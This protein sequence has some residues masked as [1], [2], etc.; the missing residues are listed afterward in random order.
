MH[1]LLDYF[2]KYNLPRWSILIIDLLIC[3]FSLTLAFFLRFNFKSIPQ[4]ELDN[5]PLIYSV[6]LSVRLCAFIISKIY[7]GV[8]RY[9]GAR[10]ATRIF[11]IIL[12]KSSNKFFEWK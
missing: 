10:D 8:V 11:V 3:A 2:W 4:S 1:K 5:F 9:T 12:L 7:K 6:L